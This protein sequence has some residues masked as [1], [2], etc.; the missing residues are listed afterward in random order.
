MRGVPH[1]GGRRRAWA[2]LAVLLLVG[3][4]TACDDADEV[5]AADGD[6]PAG[7]PEPLS[8]EEYREATRAF[9]S[10]RETYTAEVVECAA[11]E[12]V[13]V[14]TTWDDGFVL[15]PGIAEDEVEDYWDT[16]SGCA[17]EIYPEERTPSESEIVEHY[18]ML[19]AARD[20]LEDEGY[21]PTEPTGLPAFL[22]AYASGGE[23]LP[24]SPYEGVL[25]GP[26]LFR[27]AVEACPQPGR[28]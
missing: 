13:E 11:R 19:L 9:L 4:L 27:E 26:G 23:V 15:P 2:W 7:E 10:E 21:E 12:G 3:A 14:E 1:D 5:D 8:Q 6:A 28:F 17:E 20:C 24:W 22:D 25:R 18:R 16:V